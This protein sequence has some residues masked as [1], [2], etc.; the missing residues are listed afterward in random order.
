MEARLGGS[1][2]ELGADRFD[3]VSI[4]SKIRFSDARCRSH[5]NHARRFVEVKL[6][7]IDKAHDAAG[8]LGVK[9]AIA[10]GDDLSSGQALN[11][12]FQI[13]E[14]LLWRSAV[15]DRFNLVRG[16]RAKAADTIGRRGTFGKLPIF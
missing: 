9:I 8:E 10:F 11:R 2:L 6:Y 16:I 5:L 7:V 4:D 15:V 3:A 14:S 1:G 13:C 12:L